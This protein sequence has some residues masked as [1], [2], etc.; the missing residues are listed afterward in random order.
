MNGPTGK[1][2]PVS[3]DIP[4]V[5]ELI[6]PYWNNMAK[7]NWDFARKGVSERPSLK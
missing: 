4:L 2:K 6:G 5:A 7:I 1:A 3:G